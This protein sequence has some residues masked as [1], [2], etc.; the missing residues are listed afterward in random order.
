MS[1]CGQLWA[2][3]A[4]TVRHAGG[5]PEVITA[6]GG[7][8]DTETVQQA[9]STGARVL[10][11]PDGAAAQHA[12]QPRQMTSNPLAQNMRA[13]LA[14]EA[15]RALYRMRQA[16]VEPVFGYIKH[17]RGFRRFALRGIRRVRA[18]WRIICL[19]HNLL[20]LFRH[21]GRLEA[22]GA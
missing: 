16:I 4:S 2:M 22:A 7:Y 1:D 15:G 11:S 8:W 21:G 18:E 9:V 17:M 19:T 13:Q 12:G 14:T 5:E 20:K 3:M 10:V 6:D